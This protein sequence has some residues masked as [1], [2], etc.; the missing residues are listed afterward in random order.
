MEHW[1][2][3]GT[4]RHG[5]IQQLHPCSGRRCPFQTGGGPATGS[6]H[7]ERPECWRGMWSYTSYWQR[8]M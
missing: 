7:E 1:G 8:Y 2:T 3:E 4:Q 5:G 6:A